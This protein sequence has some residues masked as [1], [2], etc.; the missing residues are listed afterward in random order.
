[1][2]DSADRKGLTVVIT[3]TSSGIGRG[4]AQQLAAQGANVVLAARRTDVIEEIAQAYGPNVIA[5]TTDISK[6]EDIANLSETAISTF[7]K[8]DVW[9]NNAGV[10]TYGSFTETPL[11]DL[12]RTVEINMLG[13]I[14]GTH[15][16][17]RHFKEQKSGT[18]IN[19]ASFASQAAVPFG[20]VY[21]GTKAAVSGLSK[22]LYQE[23]EE[24]GFE[25]I[26][27]CVVDP[28]VTDTPWT[29]HAGNYSG[30]EILVGPADDPQKVIDAIIGLIDKPQEQV[31]IGSKVAG[32]AFIGN[33]V[34]GATDKS[35]GKAL[36]QML[37][38]APPAPLTSGSLHE[39]HPEGTGVSGDLRERLERKNAAD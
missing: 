8:I 34:P 25:D 26:H 5:V 22:G 35:T 4:T 9:I 12:V 27:V 31:E 30:H 24:D 23:M 1:M 11:A 2:R 13:T 36:H 10:G 39:S 32:T 29:A 21:T 17:L 28:W 37:M 19:I 14:Y 38:E 7:G 6:E 16:A 33:V 15:Y 3:G 18:L 20:A